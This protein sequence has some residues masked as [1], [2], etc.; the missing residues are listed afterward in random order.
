MLFNDLVNNGYD[1]INIIGINSINAS[2][3]DL[4]GM[5]SQNSLPWLQD[6]KTENVWV[7]WDVNIRDF[8][9]FDKSGEYF[10]KVNLTQID[11]EVDQNYDNIKELLI[12]ALGE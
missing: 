10:A 6:N 2:E 5:I 3:D 9:I 7:K 12:D 11:P 1:K 8:F 4:N